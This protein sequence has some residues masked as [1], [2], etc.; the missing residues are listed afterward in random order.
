MGSVMWWIG[1]LAVALFFELCKRVG[2]RNA[3]ST[4]WHFAGEIGPR[5]A[6]ERRRRWN[7]RLYGMRQGGYVLSRDESRV[8]ID[9]RRHDSRF[10]MGYA[11]E[12]VDYPTTG[13][14]ANYADADHAPTTWPI[15]VQEWSDRR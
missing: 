6:A 14:E 9:D 15:R 12:L 11:G 10:A 1:V 8:G 7:W 5:D 13:R 2:F 4:V 3:C